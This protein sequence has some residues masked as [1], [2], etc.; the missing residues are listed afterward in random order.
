M[1]L[2]CS[3]TWAGTALKADQKKPTTRGPSSRNT[4]DSQKATSGMRITSLAARSRCTLVGGK[5]PS[6]SARRVLK[7]RC[8]MASPVR[9]K[10]TITTARVTPSTRRV[11]SGKWMVTQV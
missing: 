10:T 5:V 7:R 4:N 1:K 6:P 2:T 11:P 8:S 3:T 9:L